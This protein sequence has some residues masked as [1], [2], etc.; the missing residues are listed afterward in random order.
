MTDALG[1][2]NVF[3]IIGPRKLFGREWVL[4]GGWLIRL[5]RHMVAA[6]GTNAVSYRYHTSVV[7][8]L[9]PNPDPAACPCPGG[10]SNFPLT[11]SRLRATDPGAF[12]VS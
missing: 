8:E 7:Q 2:A 9:S 5:Q 1:L 4:S 10:I 6:E 11:S 3:L 12:L